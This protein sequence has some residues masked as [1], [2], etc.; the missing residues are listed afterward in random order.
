VN[1]A[2]HG[3]AVPDV[4]G[5]VIDVD[6]PSVTFDAAVAFDPIRG[7]IMNVGPVA[8][9]EHVP[10]ADTLY[11]FPGCMSYAGIWV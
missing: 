5:V 7:V 1:S 3:R 2:Y 8:V 11:T 6:A 10:P 9:V 4:A